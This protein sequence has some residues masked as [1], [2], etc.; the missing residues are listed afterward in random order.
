MLALAGARA[1]ALKPLEANIHPAPWAHN[2]AAPT[3]TSHPYVRHAAEFARPHAHAH[4]HAHTHAHTHVHA[5][6]HAHTHAQAYVRTQ[7]H[8]QHL[9]ADELSDDSGRSAD[10]VELPSDHVISEQE[11][12]DDGSHGNRSAGT[13][14]NAS[15]E[16]QGD[17]R[18]SLK[19]SPL[20]AKRT[21]L[22]SVSSCSDHSIKSLKEKEKE[23]HNGHESFAENALPNSHPIQIPGFD[24]ARTIRS[25]PNTDHQPTRTQSYGTSPP[26]KSLVNDNSRSKS[27]LGNYIKPSPL[28]IGRNSV[29]GANT[30]TTDGT[31]IGTHNGED[32]STNDG[33]DNG[34]D[35]DTNTRTQPTP[36]IAISHKKQPSIGKAQFSF[37]ED[38]FGSSI[39]ED[40]GDSFHGNHPSAH[41][42]DP[43]AYLHHCV[44]AHTSQFISAQISDSIDMHGNTYQAAAVHMP[45]CIE[46]HSGSSSDSPD[47][48]YNLDTG[49]E[50]A[51][52]PQFMDAHVSTDSVFRDD[53]ASVD[54]ALAFFDNDDRPSFGR[55]R[56]R[57]STA[58]R[59]SDAEIDMWM[60]Q[61]KVVALP[62]VEHL[63]EKV[64]RNAPTLIQTSKKA[65]S[66]SSDYMSQCSTDS[67]SQGSND[68][69]ST[70]LPFHSVIGYNLF[71]T[72][73]TTNTAGSTRTHIHTENETYPLT[74]KGAN[75]HTH[76][77]DDLQSNGACDRLTQST[78]S[79]SSS[80]SS[81]SNASDSSDSTTS[82]ESESES[83]SENESGDQSKSSD[84]GEIQLD[85]S[86]EEVVGTDK[87]VRLSGVEHM[88][89]DER[90][91]IEKTTVGATEGESQS[92]LVKD[93]SIF[94][95]LLVDTA[96][97]EETSSDSSTDGDEGEV[98]KASATDDKTTHQQATGNLS[99]YDAAMSTEIDL[100]ISQSLGRTGPEEGG[101]TRSFCRAELKSSYSTTP[102]R[103]HSNTGF[104]E[105]SM[106][107][108]SS[109][110]E[111]NDEDRI[112]QGGWSSSDNDTNITDTYGGNA[113][114][115]SSGAEDSDDD[116]VFSD[117]VSIHTRGYHGSYDDGGER[118][119]GTH[120]DD[121]RSDTSD[122]EILFANMSSNVDVLADLNI[123][124][125]LQHNEESVP[126]SNI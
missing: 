6:T 1:D 112:V 35:S 44:E 29:P 86:D 27:S 52:T 80:S 37:D 38:V 8:A 118:S 23:I 58:H 73:H 85:H 47:S 42:P 72:D 11:T 115:P 125:A 63:P 64:S 113:G 126:N 78:R 103:S 100:T 89:Y 95:M 39:D 93:K 22:R 18:G 43:H 13:H 41:H 111:D 117:A 106:G 120:G 12:E 94:R 67:D 3:A 74:L 50:R 30:G 55:Y 32:E 90:G 17:R 109:G 40:R 20:D 98:H 110:S 88:V 34:T 48:V 62:S 57:L 2:T 66:M 116:V 54:A 97:S 21:R 121:D 56:E 16:G 10:I 107:L 99:K 7:G 79:I 119:I 15:G 19:L 84:I 123:P 51:H 33:M 71:Q 60:S 101:A 83:E 53:A 25:Q 76:T 24:V 9:H 49:L 65:G 124:T 46:A 26:I 92:N 102:N 69:T 114:E 36:P 5:H 105:I 96:D 82:S 70:N 28:A 59:Q 91:R 81:S 4:V 104:S 45:H 14:G 75:T 61:A 68:E 108:S 122:L 31:T 77:T 87:E